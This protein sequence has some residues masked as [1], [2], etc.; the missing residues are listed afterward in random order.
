MVTEGSRSNRKRNAGFYLILNA[1]H[2][3]TLGKF[4]T[5][6]TSQSSSSGGPEDF[7]E[8]TQL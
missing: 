7:I 8:V 5:V 2:P 4:L 6:A 3:A 1:A